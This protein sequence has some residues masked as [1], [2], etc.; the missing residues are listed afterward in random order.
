VRSRPAH[1]GR[2]PTDTCRYGNAGRQPLDSEIREW[3]AIMDHLRKLPAK[4]GELSV[5]PVNERA[6]EM[7]AIKAS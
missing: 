3:Q 7:R 6:N 4:N 2:E 5:I 1:L